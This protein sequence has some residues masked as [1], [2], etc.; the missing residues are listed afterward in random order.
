LD[1]LQRSCLIDAG[2]GSFGLYPSAFKRGKDI[3]ALEP[4]R[5]GD[6]VNSFFR[7]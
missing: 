5:F 1:R 7:H 4:L 6:L 3:L 2:G